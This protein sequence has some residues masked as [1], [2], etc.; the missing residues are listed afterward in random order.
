[1]ASQIKVVLKQDVD[2][3]GHGGDVVRVRPGFA[4]NYLLPRGLAMTASPGN[5]ARL[6]EVKKAAQAA[7]ARQLDEAKKQA[8]SLEGV[9]VKI[10]RSVGDEGRMY[11][12]VTGRDIEEA[13]AAAGHV[14]DR[15][16][17]QLPEPIKALGPATV[18]LKLHPAVSASLK[19]EVV[20]KA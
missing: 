20:K 7:A 5:L 12:S 11:G 10:E 6:D 4:R 1:M 13:F 8:A 15:K 19:L 16:K 14:I 17:L 2:N 3:L 9:Q 18:V